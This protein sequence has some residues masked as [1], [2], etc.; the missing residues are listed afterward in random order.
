[1]Q[2]RQGTSFLAVRGPSSPRVVGRRRSEYGPV[3][4]AWSTFDSLTGRLTTA[5][6]G[7][8]STALITGLLDVFSVGMIGVVRRGLRSEEREQELLAELTRARQ[9]I[10]RMEERDHEL[11]N[12]VEGVRVLVALLDGADGARA[13]ERDEAD[14]QVW[15]VTQSELCRIGQL[16]ERGAEPGA[17]EDYQ[18]APVVEAV[19]LAHGAGMHVEIDVPPELTVHGSPSVLTHVV[20]NLL[21]NCRRYAAGSAVHVQA[22]RGSSELSVEVSDDGAE[23][24]AEQTPTGVGIGLSVCRRLLRAEGGR[25]DPPEFRSDGGCTVRVGLREAP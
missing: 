1:M 6:S 8:R 16:L 4:A 10:H 14:R 3:G 25:V 17:I 5:G 12:A 19:V 24:G 9:G 11:R 7:T 23:R 20:S 2:T 21:G 22:R 13:S 15:S 18:L